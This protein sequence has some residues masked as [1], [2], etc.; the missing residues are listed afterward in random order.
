MINGRQEPIRTDPELSVIRMAIV[1]TVQ[2]KAQSRRSGAGVH[3]AP[4]L[5][6]LSLLTFI[7]SILLLTTHRFTDTGIEL[8]T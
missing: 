7:S 2:N 1:E 4:T 3:T 6:L 8:S 5:L